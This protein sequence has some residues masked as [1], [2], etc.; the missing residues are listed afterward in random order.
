[1]KVRTYSSLPLNTLQE[2][3]KL[4]FF[5]CVHIGSERFLFWSEKEVS[6]LLIAVCDDEPELCKS[7]KSYLYNYFNS[8]NIDSVIDIFP[9]G[10]SLTENCL[11]YDLIILDYQMPGINGLQTAQIIR[12]KNCFCTIIFLTSFPEIVYDTF[13]YDTF[14]FLIKPLNKKELT[15]ALD[16]FRRKL[17]HYYPITLSFN[18]ETLKIDTKEIIYIE[19]DGKNSIIRMKEKTLHY[20]KTLAYAFSLL[21]KTCFYKTHRSFIVNFA[22]ID[23]Y[24]KK[25]IR[26]TNGEYARISRNKFIDFQKS[27]NIY[28]NDIAF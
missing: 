1:M 9:E 25:H 24:N 18:G 4:K 23:K 15:E 2:K 20:P 10:N 17:N 5:L 16:S 8:H 14:R 22:Y 13:K 26:F 7:L 6:D 19:A 27:I 3:N 21:P 11:K 28:L 12:T